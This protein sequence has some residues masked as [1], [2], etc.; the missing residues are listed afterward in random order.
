VAQNQSSVS[1]LLQATDCPT[2]KRLSS[3]KMDINT[4]LV[5]IW[6]KQFGMDISKEW[7]KKEYL[8]RF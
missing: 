1:E 4:I 5:D 7:M 6:A 3:G 2:Y 8:R